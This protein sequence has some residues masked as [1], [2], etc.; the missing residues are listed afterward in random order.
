M[1]PCQSVLMA[2]NLACK[3]TLM[4][5]LSL[6]SLQPLGAFIFLTTKGCTYGLGSAT[7]SY[8]LLNP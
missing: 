1:A 5:C 6:H 2:G 8:V 3:P 7:G 4:P